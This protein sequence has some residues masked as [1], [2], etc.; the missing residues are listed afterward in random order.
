MGQ[1]RQVI[2]VLCLLTG[3][4]G[5]QCS[6]LLGCRECVSVKGC[7]FYETIN[8]ATLC[9]NNGRMRGIVLKIKTKALCTVFDSKH[10]KMNC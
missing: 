5:E 10:F 6:S 8:G 2:V 9:S 1:V 7:L 4:L 3:M